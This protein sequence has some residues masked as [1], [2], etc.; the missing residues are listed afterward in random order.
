MNQE[1]LHKYIIGEAS[2]KEKEDLIQWLDASESNMNE[3]LLLHKLYDINMW[4]CDVSSAAKIQNKDRRIY[5]LSKEVLKIAAVLF[6]A[7]TLMYTF[8][9]ISNKRKIQTQTIHV[10][11]GQRAE[12]ILSDGTKV[13][14]NA[15]TTFTF[16]TIFDS[17]SRNVVLN[18]EGYFDVARDKKKTFIVKTKSYDIKVLG[19]EFNVIAYDESDI[20]E[21]ALFRGS[22]Q[23]LSPKTGKSIQMSPDMRVY[24]K[25]GL[26]HQSPIEYKNQYMWKEGLLC[27]NEESVEDMFEKLQL[28]YDVKIV[29]RNQAL[30][31]NKYTGKFRIKEGIEHVLRVLQLN[32]KFVYEKN[33]VENTITVK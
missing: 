17:D 5:R 25:E 3:F 28:Y 12:V 32:N 23:I 15:K 6:V 10:P 1:L 21:T 2:L 13:W 31:K 20:F 4:R 16:P 26:L 24:L 19:T 27:F 18:G 7:F 29:V 22:V 8:N 9:T 30:L 14:L 33:D 11:A